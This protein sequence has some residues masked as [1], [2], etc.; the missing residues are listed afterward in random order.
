MPRRPQ[1]GQA[2]PQLQAPGAGSQI[3]GGC[4]I[5]SLNVEATSVWGAPNVS[6]PTHTSC[7]VRA[8][9][10]SDE[11]IRTGEAGGKRTGEHLG[12]LRPAAAT[13][14]SAPPSSADGS[15]TGSLISVPCPPARLTA[16][17]TLMPYPQLRAA[18]VNAVHVANGKYRGQRHSAIP[19]WACEEC[20]GRTR[21]SSV[22]D[23]SKWAASCG[24]KLTSIV[25]TSSWWGSQK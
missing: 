2:V 3:A 16:R 8:G 14:A 19:R 9:P 25:T 15:P 23:S 13:S 11:R 7:G 24:R 18:P 1:P 6:A 17:A 4:R 5:P 20:H 21:A 10:G 12:V 22:P